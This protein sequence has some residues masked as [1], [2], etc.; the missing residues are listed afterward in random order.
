MAPPH[1]L[2]SEILVCA[3]LIGE[4][5]WLRGKEVV[6]FEMEWPGFQPQTSSIRRGCSIHSNTPP[7]GRWIC[8]I[9][10]P[11]TTLI[12]SQGDITL[13][14]T[15]PTQFTLASLSKFVSAVNSKINSYPLMTQIPPSGSALSLGLVSIPAG[16]D[17]FRR[18][19]PEES[20]WEIAVANGPC[21]KRT[22]NQ[23]Y[24]SDW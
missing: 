21:L 4:P 10:I 1:S 11:M 15:Q 13:F 24:S 19:V 23:D 17:M 3:Q 9:W 2:N 16:T 22:K 6:F 14:L 5:P 20:R 7:P 8:P 12:S 18:D